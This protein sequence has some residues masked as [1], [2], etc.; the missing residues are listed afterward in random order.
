MRAYSRKVF[1]TSNRDTVT[2]AGGCFW[3][4]EAAFKNID[5]TDSGGSFYDR[6]VQY[7]SVIFY[8][9][10]R[11]KIAAEKSRTSLEKSGIFDKEIVTQIVPYRNF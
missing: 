9:N 10:S 1:Q 7:R 2:L 3:C 4:V 11:Q 8:H 5:P 6:G